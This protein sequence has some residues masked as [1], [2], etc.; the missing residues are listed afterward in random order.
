MLY[1]TSYVGLEG[2]N[3]R[4]KAGGRRPDRTVVCDPYGENLAKATLPGSGWTYH[5]DAINVQ[6]CKIARQAGLT[7]DTE[8][9]DYFLRMLRERAV[10]PN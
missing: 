10:P 2:Q 8:I 5:H 6:V 4:Q 3:I 1:P 9:G 7:S